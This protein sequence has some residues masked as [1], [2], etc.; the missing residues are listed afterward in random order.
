MWNKAFGYS[1]TYSTPVTLP[2]TFATTTLAYEMCTMRST[3]VGKTSPK[4]GRPRA[5][6]AAAVSA[7][8]DG[9]MDLMQQVLHVEQATLHRLPHAVQVS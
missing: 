8:L 7:P 3:R 5:E 4:V 1:T 9:L 2:T 6:N